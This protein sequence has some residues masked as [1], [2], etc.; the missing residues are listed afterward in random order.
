MGFWAEVLA[1]LFSQLSLNAAHEAAE[2][3]GGGADDPHHQRTPPYIRTVV[4]P[5][6]RRVRV[7]SSPWVLEMIKI[8]V[9]PG[10]DPS[11]TAPPRLLFWDDLEATPLDSWL[12]FERVLHV[13]TRH[14][15]P[16]GGGQ[17][18]ISPAVALQFREAV[19]AAVGI[20]LP[21]P[22]TPPPRTITYL[23]PTDG[24]GVENNKQVLET[25]RRAAETVHNGG[26][27]T[28]STTTSTTSNAMFSVR[29]YSPT[30]SVPLVSLVA[31]MTR[32]GLLVGRHSPLIANSLFL[33]PGA[34][35]AEILPF[36]WDFA[37]L[38]EVYKNLTESTGRLGHVAWRAPTSDWMSYATVSDARYASWL[39][40]EC[41]SAHCLDA[42][43]RAAVRVNTTE[44]EVV[45]EDALRAV[46]TREEPEQLRMRYPWPSRAVLSGKTGLWWDQKEAT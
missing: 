32:T 28:T 23:M 40:T 22:G 41:S 12:G 33:P 43:N 46:I 7:L 2:A 13:Y 6:L 29:P 21:L 16:T 42:H 8:A 38:N 18:F 45:I 4:I 20:P 31:V 26:S 30:P 35:V 25:L 11:K 34:V 24:A 14:K 17:G 10:M 36:N 37:G 15:H 44:L 39:P 1:P 3:A 27:S 5:Q 9:R 19:H